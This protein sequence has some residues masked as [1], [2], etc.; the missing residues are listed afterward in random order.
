MYSSLSRP[1]HSA[2][3]A[4]SY[5]VADLQGGP[6]KTGPRISANNFTIATR[7]FII[8]AENKAN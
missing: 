8:L 1:P 2:Y 5:V 3:S 4:E 6:N 7:I